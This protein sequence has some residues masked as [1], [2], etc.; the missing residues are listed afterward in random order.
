[1]TPLSKSIS[2]Y[3]IS[4]LLFWMVRISTM[5]EAFVKADIKILQSQTDM[6]QYAKTCSQPVLQFV[7]KVECL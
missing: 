1:M 7:V 4:D 2:N 3:E 6:H 5:L